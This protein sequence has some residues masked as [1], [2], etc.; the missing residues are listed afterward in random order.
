MFDI[1]ALGA[2]K[3]TELQEI[4]AQL[5][6]SK[7]KTLKKQ[8]LVYQ[9]LDVQAQR[10]ERVEQLAAAEKG[11]ESSLRKRIKLQIH[12]T[13]QGLNAIVKS[14]AVIVPNE[15]SRLPKRHILQERPAPIQ[16]RVLLKRRLLENRKEMQ[17]QTAEQNTIL[18]SAIIAQITA[19]TKLKKTTIL[20]KT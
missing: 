16:K 15:E 10:P 12:R 8:D 20:T 4:A 11:E 2:K 18:N 13:Q 5:K 17:T 3:L 9:I 7:F 14:A 19:T 6:I 1:D